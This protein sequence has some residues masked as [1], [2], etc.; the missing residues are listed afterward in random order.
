MAFNFFYTVGILTIL[1]PI[2]LV[3]IY[4]L[5]RNNRRKRIIID[6]SDLSESEVI[7]VKTLL[8][9]IRLRRR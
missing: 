8:E 6:I 1:L 5:T 2:T 7:E 9:T 4:F 3:I